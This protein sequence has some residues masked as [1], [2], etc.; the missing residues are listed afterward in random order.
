MSKYIG[1]TEK[2]LSE[3]FNEAQYSNAILFFDEADAL[4][5]KRTEVSDS[6]DKYS[7]VETSY[8]LQKI[9]EYEGIAIL[10]SN[11]LVNFDDAFKRRI[12][13][14]INFQMPGP[15]MRYKLWRK[16]F[17]KEA[18]TDSSVDFEFL[19]DTFEFTGSNIKNIVVSA[20]YMAAAEGTDISMR[21]VVGAIR[22]ENAKFGKVLLKHEFGRYAEFY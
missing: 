10:A 7:N 19:A 22:I 8:L 14:I 20:A 1:E 13:F 6:K 2:N 4:F 3:L 18:P 17:P 9:E 11:Y 12:K 5:S 16:M 15:E 21:H